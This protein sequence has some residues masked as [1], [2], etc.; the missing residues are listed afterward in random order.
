[1]QHLEPQLELCLKFCIFCERW[2]GELL[3]S[4][5]EEEGR[6]FFG[7]EGHAKAMSFQDMIESTWHVCPHG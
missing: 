2:M 4:N 6:A 1:M 5:N 3:R 7:N